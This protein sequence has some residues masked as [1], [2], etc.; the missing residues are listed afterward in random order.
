MTLPGGHEPVEDDELLYRRIPVS[1]NWYT[2]T[3]LSP[4]AFDPRRNETTGISVSR[5]KYLPIELAATGRSKQGYYVA[6][7]RAGDLRAAG[8][9][10]VPRPEPDNPGHAELPGLTCSNRLE[11][12]AAERKVR[13]AALA[14][15]VEGPFVP[16]Q[17][18]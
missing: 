5:A 3:R 4:E 1:M 18:Q 17:Q 11:E 10:V 2:S 16:P 12:I 9:D 15:S 13:L 6:V 7:L 14:L 8:I